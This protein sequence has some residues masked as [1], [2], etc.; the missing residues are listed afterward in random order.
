MGFVYN[1]ECGMWGGDVRKIPTWLLGWVVYLLF[2]KTDI[3]RRMMDC[4]CIWFGRYYGN[5][6]W[7]VYICVLGGILYYLT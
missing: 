5:H 4:Y 6:A 7:L 2:T 3:S 1:A